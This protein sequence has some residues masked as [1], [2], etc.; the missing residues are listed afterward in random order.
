[1]PPGCLWLLE[2]VGERPY[3]IDRMLTS[4]LVAGSLRD[5]AGVVVGELE[6]CDA[7]ADGVTAEAVVAERLAALSVPIVCGAP[8]G[9]GQRND[10]AVLGLVARLTAEGAQA[11]LELGCHHGK[12]SSP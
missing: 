8:I 6:Q 11:T 10:P 5:V 12:E 7:G 4:L 2:D 9:H 1:V 3:R